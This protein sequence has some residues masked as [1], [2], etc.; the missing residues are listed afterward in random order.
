VQLTGCSWGGQAAVES[1]DDGATVYP[2]GKPIGTVHS[3]VAEIARQ[4]IG[5][6]YRYGGRTPDGFDCS[7][8]V[9]FSYH[10]AGISVPRSSKEQLKATTP[11]DL[12]EAQP[13]DLLFFRNWLKVSH[14]AIYL[15]DGRFVHAPSTGKQVSVASM[16]NAYYREH[17]VRAGRF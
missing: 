12:E 11:I 13:G 10:Q 2:G 15:G 1:R 7:G 4:M 14:V 17:F 9:Y 16:D 3:N 8:L 5:T 6:P